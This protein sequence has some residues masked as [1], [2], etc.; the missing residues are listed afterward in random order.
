MDM[1]QARNKRKMTQIELAIKTGLSQTALSQIETGYA[2][3]RESTRKKI[4]DVLGISVDWLSTRM[5]P[6]TATRR[7]KLLA[8]TGDEEAMISAI[9]D[10]VRTGAGAERQAAKISFLKG[11][12]DKFGKSLIAE[13]KSKQKMKRRNN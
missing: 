7:G 5:Q 4:E 8:E 12:L 1:R 3:P 13:K 10:Y 6:D 11:Y 9:R 2:Y